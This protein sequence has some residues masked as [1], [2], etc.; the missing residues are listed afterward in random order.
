MTK[1]IQVTEAARRLGVTRQTVINWG[2]RGIIKLHKVER[3]FHGYVYW[4]DENVIDTLSDV[5]TDI[6][7]AKKKLQ[8]ELDDIRKEMKEA[9][10][11]RRDIRNHIFLIKKFGRKTIA[12]NF[13]LAIPDML[14]DL[15]IIKAHDAEIMKDVIGG[16]DMET[17]SDKYGV[18]WTQI[19]FIFLRGCRKAVQLTKVKQAVDRCEELEKENAMLLSQ[20]RILSEKVKTQEEEAINADE[21]ELRDLCRCFNTRLEDYRLSVRALNCLKAADVETVGDLVRCTKSDLL[22]FRNFGKKS[23]CELEDLIEDLGFTFGMN[24][25]KYQIALLNAQFNNNQ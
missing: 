16:M 22:K 21:A 9:R 4:V 20:L 17:I 11:E 18:T 8:K 23:L 12:E 3:G 2:E 15:D 25:D 13:Y 14:R 24:I 19:S 5:T 1:R 6:H 7:A 10:K